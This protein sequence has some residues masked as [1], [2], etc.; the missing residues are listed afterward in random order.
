[1]DF[2]FNFFNWIVIPLMIFFARVSDVSL[3]TMRIISLSR[4]LRKIA[5]VLGFFEILIWLFAIRQIFNHLNNP[6]C[7][8]AYAGGFASGIFT[9]MWIEEKLALGL[10]VIRV[11]TKL[12]A[13]NLI[14]E[15]R[16]L[17]YGVTVADAE[18]NKGKVKIVFTLVKRS[19]IPEI[20]KLIKRFNPK[21]FYSIEDV[22]AAAEGNFPHQNTVFSKFMRFEKKG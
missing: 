19:D 2:Q 6:V 16:R 7:Y 1:M 20:I 14:T 10:R 18:G 13:K 8:L 17:G 21:A 22:R 11:I 3:G 4:G 12:D 15:L 5:P 9:G